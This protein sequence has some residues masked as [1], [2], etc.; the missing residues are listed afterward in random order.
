MNDNQ[1]S[2]SSLSG[3]Q[4]VNNKRKEYDNKVTKFNDGKMEKGRN[5]YSIGKGMWEGKV[6]S[7][8]DILTAK[9][10]TMM[11]AGLVVIAYIGSLKPKSQKLSTRS[12]PGNYYGAELG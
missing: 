12:S 9:V 8:C 2:F 11:A 3:G 10:L 5:R 7:N 6:N 1:I 4:V